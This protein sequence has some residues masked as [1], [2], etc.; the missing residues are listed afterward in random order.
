LGNLEKAL[1]FYE[2]ETQLFEQLYVAYPNDVSFKNGLA[3]SYAQLGV[4]CRDKKQDKAK[5]K[6]YFQS[7]EKHWVELLVISPQYAQFKK[8][9]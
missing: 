9:L 3:I 7:A 6:S 4:F 1:K 8:Y 2:E 5:A